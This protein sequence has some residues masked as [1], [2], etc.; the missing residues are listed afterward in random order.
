MQQRTQT[1]EGVVD[2]HHFDGD[3]SDAT[4]PAQLVIEI[5]HGATKT[6]HFT[7]LKAQLVG[8][9]PG[10]LVDF[11]HVNTDV[12]APEVGLALAARYVQQHPAHRVEVLVCQ[13][14]R[15][16][17]DTNRVVDEN[18][19]PSTSTASGM[20]PGVVRYVREPSDLQRL[21]GLSKQYQRACTSSLEPTLLAGGRAIMLHTYAPRS[22][23]VPVDEHIVAALHDAYRPER[24]S[25]WP[26][27]ASIDVIATTP[28]GAMVSDA[29]WVQRV[30]QQAAAV[31]V[32]VTV[33]GTYALHPSTAAH[34]WATRFVGQTLCVE[35]R[36]DLVVQAFT[37]FAEMVADDDK[38][39]RFAELLLRTLA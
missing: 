24:V 15:T 2:I 31:D 20:T 22:V 6:R 30:Q 8:P 12:G 19:Q 5:P 36:R 33:S 17:I 28:D 26:L 4:A 16:F 7:A 32:D 37:P 10:D 35:L 11:F 29:Q 18:T 14:P 39:A 27:R 23:D 25:Q 3:D 34:A 9:F 21:L 1:I 38:V 13:I